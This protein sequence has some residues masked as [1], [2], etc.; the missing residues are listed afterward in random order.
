[1]ADLFRFIPT[2]R[3][4]TLVSHRFS[5]P[6]LVVA[7]AATAVLAALLIAVPGATAAKPKQVTLTAKLTGSAGSI[8]GLRV[9]VLPTRGSS[10]T[11]TP[12]GGKVTA[13]IAA[14]ALNGTSLQL[15]ARDGSY[16]GP[17]LLNRT[18]STEL[19]QLGKLAGSVLLLLG[20]LASVDV[21]DEIRLPLVGRPLRR[22][23]HLLRHPR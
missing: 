2:V 4:E 12:K 6:A 11:V 21:I 20:F 5:R 22:A 23:L 3:E 14:N 7:I 18:G 13:K 16:A 10:V 1:M 17:V 8:A 19:Y 9:L 15:I